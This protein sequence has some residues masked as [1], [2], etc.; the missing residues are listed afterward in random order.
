V[1]ERNVR[2]V[3]DTDLLA[4]YI[5]AELIMYRRDVEVKKETA[6]AT[7]GGFELRKWRSS[8]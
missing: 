6:T 3:S 4:G 2:I 7:E 1:L 5:K 8:V